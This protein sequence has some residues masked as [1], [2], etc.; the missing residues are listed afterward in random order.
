MILGFAN[1]PE[2]DE[3]MAKKVFKTSRTEANDT[4]K[5]RY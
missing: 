5:K 2:D 4:I 3:T 1:E